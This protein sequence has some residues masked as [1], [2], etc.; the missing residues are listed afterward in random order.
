MFRD[1]KD[2][3]VVSVNMAPKVSQE[4]R[5]PQDPQDHLAARVLQEPMDVR[6]TEE[7]REILVHR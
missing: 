5:A 7:Q 3:K 2:K 6:E 1:T 4:R